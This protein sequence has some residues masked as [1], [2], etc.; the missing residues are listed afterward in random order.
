MQKNT[1]KFY[2]L[3][4]F[5]I[6]C[7]AGKSQVCPTINLEQAFENAKELSL[8]DFVKDIEY[9]VLKMDGAPIELRVLR[10]MK[11]YA[12]GNTLICIGRGQVY[13]FDRRTGEFIL[14]INEYE[15]NQ[16]RSQVYFDSKTQRIITYNAKA[17]LSEYDLSGNIVRNI[18]A[19]PLPSLPAAKLTMNLLCNQIF[20]DENTLA[21]YRNA[22]VDNVKER[23][24]ISDVNGNLLNSI[25]N[26]NTYTPAKTAAWYS[27]PSLFYHYGGNTFFFENAVD[28]V[29][30][31]SKND[32]TPRYHLRSGKFQMPYL[33][34]GDDNYFQ[35][36]NI[37][38]TDQFLF[39]EFITREIITS[40]RMKYFGYYNKKSEIVK[41]ADADSNNGKLLVNDV[42]MFPAVQL[43]GWT[44]NTEQNEMISCIEANELAEWIK[45]NPK[46]LPEHLKRMSSLKTNNPLVVVIAKLK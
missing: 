40:P 8:S 25:K 29:F 9:V 7:F 10:E 27:T 28:T 14:E 12:S 1:K 33:P 35:F 32:F 18:V 20:L 45:N 16:T 37:G 3:F 6:I 15:W 21:Y 4:I 38:E 36:K 22:G 19:P 23:L 11:V 17:Q 24:L 26:Y 31:V 5:L 34:D 46:K 2:Y 41:I 44:I 42:D 30:R 39:F 43:N 13:L